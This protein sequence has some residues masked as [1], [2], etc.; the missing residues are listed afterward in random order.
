MTAKRLRLTV[1]R[2]TTIWTVKTHSKWCSH[3][4]LSCLRW[5]EIYRQ[6]GNVKERTLTCSYQFGCCLCEWLETS[7]NKTF[8]VI[9][10]PQ[11]EWYGLCLEN[12]LDVLKTNKKQNSNYQ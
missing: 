11:E 9:L 6:C 5:D 10:L 8:Q 2:N 3:T 7:E 4:S 1:R 12:G